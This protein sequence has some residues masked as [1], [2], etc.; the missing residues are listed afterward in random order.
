MRRR[1]LDEIKHKSSGDSERIVNNVYGSSPGSGG[2]IFEG[3]RGTTEHDDPNDYMV[4]ID[5]EDKLDPEGHKIGWTKRVRR[6]KDK[7]KVT[8]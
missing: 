2:G 6:Y 3:L 5:R 7:K 1:L 4:D 8:P